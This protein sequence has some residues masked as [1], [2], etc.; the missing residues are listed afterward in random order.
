[1]FQLA[2]TIQNNLEDFENKKHLMEL[3]TRDRQKIF[4]EANEI[5]KEK[6][7]T[8]KENFNDMTDGELKT[9]VKKMKLDLQTSEN[10][11]IKVIF[12]SN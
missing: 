8:L 10:A 5:F 11:Y 7:K 9:A 12:N 6:F 4:R 1:M 2:T 3:D